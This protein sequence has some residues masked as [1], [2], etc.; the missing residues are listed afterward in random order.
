MFSYL[1]NVRKYIINF[2]NKFCDKNNYHFIKELLIL[3]KE[4]VN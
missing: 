1:T 2:S 3:T 4:D